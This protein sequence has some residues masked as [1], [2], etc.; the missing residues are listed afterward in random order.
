MKTILLNLFFIFI[1]SNSSQLFAQSDSIKFTTKCNTWDCLEKNKNTYAEIIGIFRKFTPN[2][3]G[4]GANIMYWDWELLL[5]DGYAVPVSNSNK[6]INYL[7]FNGK[8]ICL[9]GLIYNGVVI[10]SSSPNGQQATGF[11]LDPFE[12]SLIKN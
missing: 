8:K 7:S 11:R 3:Q 2:Q 12:I 1:I 4:K 10:K 6:K 5:S 9:K